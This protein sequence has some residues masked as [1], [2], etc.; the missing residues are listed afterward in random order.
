M[1]TNVTFYSGAI[2]LDYLMT[3]VRLTFGDLDGSV[4]S[5]TIIRTGIVNAVKYLQRKWQNKYQVFT[6][7]II[8]TPQPAVI[9]DGMVWANTADGQGFIPEDLAEGS[10]FRNPFVVFTQPS[11][12]IVESGDET[13]IVLAATYLLR[14]SQVSSSV[15]SFVSWS[16]EDIRYSNLGSERGLSGLL[17]SDLL[18][19]NDY[20]Q[21]RIAQ[22]QRSEFPIAYIPQEFN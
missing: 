21:S 18:A 7:S 1:T 11:P 19:L 17:E 9:P 14:R 4:Y 8:D 3:D 10:A 16:T 12:P 22:P 15:I 6:E 20:F 13:A 5:D 2:N